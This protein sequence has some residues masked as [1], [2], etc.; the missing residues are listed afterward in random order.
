LAPGVLD[1]APTMPGPLR[2]S[3]GL[4]SDPP[5]GCLATIFNPSRTMLGP[6]QKARFKEALLDSPARFKFIVNEVAI[7]QRWVLPYDR[8]EGYG[9]ERAE[10]LNFLRDNG[11]AN[12]VFLTTDDHLNLI[13]PVFVDRFA[14]PQVIA[15]EFIAGPIA[16]LT[17]EQT[18]VAFFGPQ[19]VAI[20]QGILSLVGA[21]CRHLNAY[22]YGVVEVDASAGTATLTLKNDGGE[23]ISDQ[24]DSATQCTKTLP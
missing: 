5:A 14:D 13:T 3:F 11:L 1:P 23:V 6:V 15:S 7:Q 20:F 4:P 9:A 2:L 22:S 18:I 24:I 19:F 8:W 16:E 21:E 17:A 10:I 12:V